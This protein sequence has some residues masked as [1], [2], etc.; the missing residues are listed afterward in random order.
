MILTATPPDGDPF[1]DSIPIPLE[2]PLAGWRV[3]ACILYI[4]RKL[5]APDV[6][7]PKVRPAVPT[8]SDI[9]LVSAN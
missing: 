1:V 6:G 7:D 4:N 9:A 3:Q 2:T 8:D 5:S